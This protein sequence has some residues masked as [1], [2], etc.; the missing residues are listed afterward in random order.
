MLVTGAS[1]GIGRALA[2]QLAVAGIGV[3]ALAR[4]RERLEGLA[5]RHPGMVPMVCDLA[6]ADAL[7]PLADKVLEACP[8]LDGVIHNAAIQCD[9]RFDDADYG[10][11]CIR[12]ELHT[13]LLAPLV[14]TRRLLPTLQRRERAW[15]VTLGSALA[16]APRRSAAV[17]SASKAGLE[18]FSRA[19][20]LQS[21]GSG[22]RFVHAVMPLVDTA[23]TAG[24][25]SGKI[26]PDDAADALLN[27]IARGKHQVYVGKA[28]AV[29]WMQRLAPGVLAALMARS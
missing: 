9:Q 28:R 24:R 14:L 1:A 6:D 17:Y 5:R 13:D 21:R 25:G 20:R 16:V 11:A 19:M 4:S 2:R 26:S 27:A 3:V 7:G 23:M 18:S 10:D 8:A 15:V 22:V 12:E 29:P